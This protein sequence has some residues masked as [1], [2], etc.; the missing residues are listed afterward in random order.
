PSD[1]LKPHERPFT[2]MLDRHPHSASGRDGC[3]LVLL[4]PGRSSFGLF[5]RKW[6]SVV[7]ADGDGWRVVTADAQGLADRVVGKYGA[8]GAE[9][10]D[11]GCCADRAA[12]LRQAAVP[13]GG[14]PGR[15]AEQDGDGGQ[16]RQDLV[17]PH[18]GVLRPRGIGDSG[19][20]VAVAAPVGG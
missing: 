5:W 1:T 8:A 19:A 16:V 15:T 20:G 4:L 13:A 7:P 9:L 11:Q 6:T 10:V 2:G 3:S 18:V 17:L 14:F 12:Q